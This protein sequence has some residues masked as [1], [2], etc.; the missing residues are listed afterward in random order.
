MNVGT[1]CSLAQNSRIAWTSPPQFIDTPVVVPEFQS[2]E[3]AEN[4]LA[5]FPILLGRGEIDNQTALGLFT[6]IKNWID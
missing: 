3:Q 4:Y 6:L 5:H 2:V 1:S